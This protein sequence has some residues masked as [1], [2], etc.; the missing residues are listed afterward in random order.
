MYLEKNLTKETML[1]K[2]K[3]KEQFEKLP[4]EFSI[5]DLVERLILIEK[6]ES[7]RINRN[8]AILSRTLIWIMKLKNG[9]NKLDFPVKKTP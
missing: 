6:V 9:S 3:V 5:E 1:T 7:E 8:V 2:T 4:G